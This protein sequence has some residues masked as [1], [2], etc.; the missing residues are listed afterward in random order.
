M[1]FRRL[2]NLRLRAMLSEFDEVTS[3]EDIMM[4]EN[5]SLQP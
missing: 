3:G 1:V 5:M 2:A 4:K